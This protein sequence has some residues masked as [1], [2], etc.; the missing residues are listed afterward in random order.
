MQAIHITKAGGPEVLQFKTVELQ[1]PDKREVRIQV[2]AAG[3]NRSDI[4]TRE[5]PDA[6]GKDLPGA[7]IPGLEVAGEV[8]EVGAEVNDLL[9]G[10]KV[11]AL[12]PGGGY[13]EEVVVDERLCLPLP[14]GVNF[15]EAASLPEAIFT[16]WFNIFQ[17]G[18]IK[19]EEHLLIHGGTSGVG[20]MG[21]QIAAAMGIKTYTTVGSQEKVDFIKQHKLGSVINYKEE[22][23]ERAYKDEQIDV[24][25]DMVGG[26]Y[27][28]KNLSILN[29]N[30]RLLYINGMNGTTPEINLWTIM[31]KNLILTGSLL[32]PQSVEVKAQIAREVHKYVWPLL[33]Q[34]K[35]KPVIYKTFSLADAA[36]AHRLM[37]SSTHIGKIVL[38]VD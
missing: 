32:K 29:K 27:T 13:A 33:E 21:L 17:Q 37:E 12:I 36:E 22:D 4:L 9:V 24:I 20:I 23:F 14:A 25:L 11:C 35:V 2:K 16:V 19:S 10:D 18:K 34:K 38:S 7:T 8:I 30:G 6:Y 15:I 3:V 1:K 26:S 28:N 5:N 31:S